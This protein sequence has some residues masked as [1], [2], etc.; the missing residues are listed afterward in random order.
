[1]NTWFFD[2]QISIFFLSYTFSV[3]E[4]STQSRSYLANLVAVFLY[5]Y[6]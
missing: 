2:I 3:A 6:T 4:L 1:M 5:I